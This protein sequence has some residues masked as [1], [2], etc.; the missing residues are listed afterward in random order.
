M[1]YQ[2]LLFP[3]RVGSSMGNL[4]TNANLGNFGV[5]YGGECGLCRGMPVCVRACCGAPR[6]APQHV[7]YQ[8]SA[9]RACHPAPPLYKDLLWTALALRHR[10]VLCR[11]QN[12][13]HGVSQEETAPRPAGGCLGTVH[14]CGAAQPWNEFS[15]KDDLDP[16][17]LQRRFGSK[18]MTRLVQN[19][20]M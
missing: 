19:H 5:E 14:A 10:F 16:K 2:K 1:N 18:T 4:A 7:H 8:A 3:W 9:L 15:R 11:A 12:I 13:A 6:L 17:T 20:P